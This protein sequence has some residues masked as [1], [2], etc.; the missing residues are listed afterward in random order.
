MAQGDPE[1][2]HSMA[3][4]DE[5]K[6][7]KTRLIRLE[8]DSDRSVIIMFVTWTSTLE[9]RRRTNDFAFLSMLA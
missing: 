4:T 8:L 2:M 9:H 7:G 6:H 5:V 1:M 3:S